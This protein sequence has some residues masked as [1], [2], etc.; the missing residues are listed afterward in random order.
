MMRPK[1]VFLYSEIAGYFL[2]CVKA[3]SKDADVLVVRWQVNKEAPFEFNF[4]EGV[5]II[6]KDDFSYE[7]LKLKITKEKP[8]AIVCSGWMDKD[9]L[10]IVKSFNKRI[11]TVLTLD[12]HWTGGVKQRIASLVSPFFLKNKFKMAYKAFITRL[13]LLSFLLS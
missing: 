3:L 9:Y 10:K 13:R 8:D 4:P 1:I 5:E 2:A 7:D 12:N 6:V 11:P